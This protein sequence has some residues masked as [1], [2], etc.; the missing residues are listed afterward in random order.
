[1]AIAKPGDITET[2]FLRRARSVLDWFEPL[3]PYRVVD[4]LFKLEDANFA[5]DSQGRRTDVLEPLYAFAVS[6]KRY[7]LFN[8]DAEGRPVLRKASAHGLGHLREPYPAERAPASIPAPVVPRKDLGV[9]R[10]QHD[11]WYRIVT[12]A[13]EGHPAQVDL[14]DIEGL[15]APAVSRY[16]ATTS[17]LLHWFDRY[18]ADR[19]YR[20]QVRPFG[21][22][23]A[24]Q[25]RPDITTR[26]A[27]AG[28]RHG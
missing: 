14:A 10:W 17:E 15:D 18:N 22:L 25:A 1:M 28:T 21:F 5:L 20:Q 13:L 3:K 23:L 9:A 7:C 11:L 27:T 4:R 12:A 24:Y 2:E 26:L 16:G 19:P 8:L 6:A